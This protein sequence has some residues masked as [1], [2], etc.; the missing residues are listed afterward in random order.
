MIYHHLF[1]HQTHIHIQKQQN[2]TINDYQYPLNFTLS[3][4]QLLINQ[5]H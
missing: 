1:S 4:M 2:K 3:R 5:Q